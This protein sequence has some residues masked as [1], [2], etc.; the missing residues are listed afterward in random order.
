MDENSPVRSQL[1]VG[2]GVLLAVALLIGGIV[3]PV[4]LKAADV[5]GLNESDGTNSQDSGPPLGI[6]TNSRSPDP[7]SAPTSAETSPREPGSTGSTDSLS[8]LDTDGDHQDP[9]AEAS[10]QITLDASPTPR[11]RTSGSA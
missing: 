3:G 7:T 5:A 6:G 9:Q 4:A 2:I 8:A 10:K 11:A 1:L